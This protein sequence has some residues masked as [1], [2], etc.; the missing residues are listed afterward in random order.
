MGSGPHH[1]TNHNKPQKHGIDRGV[2]RHTSQGRSGSLDE[3]AEGGVRCVDAQAAIIND[4]SDRRALF[5]R[6]QFC[7]SFSTINFGVEVEVGGCKGY[8][9]YCIVVNSFK[10]IHAEIQVVNRH[11][12]VCGFVQEPTHNGWFKAF[13]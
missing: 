5:G 13:T 9:S 2:N 3:R 10:Q 12:C 8:R 11:A 7:V 4:H 6:C 1:A